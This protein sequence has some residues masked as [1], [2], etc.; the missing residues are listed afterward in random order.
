MTDESRPYIT[1]AFL[2]G[3]QIQAGIEHEQFDRKIKRTQLDEIL[4]ERTMRNRRTTPQ[5]V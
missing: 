1:E 2:R 3:E 4:R 5:Y